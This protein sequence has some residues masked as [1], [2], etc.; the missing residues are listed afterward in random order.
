MKRLVLA[1]AVLMVAAC[2][3]EEKPADTIKTDT[4]APA[5]APASMD[6]AMMRDSMMKDSAMMKNMKGMKKNP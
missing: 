3:T 2:K 6:S 1:A 5:M 4:S